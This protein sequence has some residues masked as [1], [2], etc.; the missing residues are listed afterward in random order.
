MIPCR[1]AEGGVQGTE[2]AAGGQGCCELLS[3]LPNARDQ[4]LM[5]SSHECDLLRKSLLLAFLRPHSLGGAVPG[6]L[7]VSTTSWLHFL[8]RAL[9]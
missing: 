5:A 7:C 3:S 2:E 9:R 8:L 4:V 1:V 6:S